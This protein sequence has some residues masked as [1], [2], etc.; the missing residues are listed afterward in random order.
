[1][2]TLV[3]GCV[4]ALL[5]VAGTLTTGLVGEAEALDNGVAFGAYAAPVDG[6]TNTTAI[7]KLER[8]LGTTLPMVRTFSKWDDAIGEDKK[9]HRWIRDG[10]RQLMASIKPQRGNGQEVRW[11]D[12]ANAQPGSK[13]HDEMLA[14][15]SGVKRYGDTVV[16]GFHHEPEHKKNLGFGTSSDYQAAFRKLHDVFEQQGVDNVRFAWIMTSWA[17]EVGDIRPDDRRIAEK[18]YPGDDVV[19]YISVQEYN[20]AT[21]RDN[22]DSW[23]TLEEG[24]EPFMRF[25]RQHPS[26]Q[27]IL[28]EF[29]TPEGNNGQKAQWLDETRALFK[30]GEYKDRFAAI[31]YFHYDDSPNGNDKCDW[32]LD[33]SSSALSAAT[34]LANDNFYRADIVAGGGGGGNDG[35]GGGADPAPPAVPTPVGDGC[36]ATRTGDTV[37]LSWSDDGR[38]PVVRRNGSWLTTLTNGTTS[39]VDRNAP[40]GATY[41]IRG[42]G[43]TTRTCA[44]GDG[45]TPDCAVNR[46]GNTV[47]LEWTDDG[48]R[49]VIRRDGKWL[50]TLGRGVDSFVDRNA[51][52]GATYELRT[53][54]GQGRIDTPCG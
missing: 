2:K 25:A 6:L 29:G 24:L 49:H 42:G 31:L 11:R 14:L 36:T 38:T 53:H 7:E 45:N 1:M 18:W 41:V 16:L 50:A 12:I 33:S 19:D 15:A 32:W 46:D 44:E 48:G 26:K 28:A 37:T 39:Y 23:D 5:M 10:D 17:F 13:I 27:L 40:A 52:N 51:P 8:Q 35:D 20:W 34:R 4:L 3:T 43:V 21:C 54:T 22:N 47:R 30:K 9:F